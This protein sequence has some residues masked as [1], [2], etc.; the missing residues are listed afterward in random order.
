MANNVEMMHKALRNELESYIRAQYLEKNELLLNV[1]GDRLDDENLLYR[2][3]YIE[4]TPAYETVENGIKKVDLPEW[5]KH[6]FLSLSQA[7]LGV[8]PSPYKHQLDALKKAYDGHDLFISTGTG[9]GKT[10]CFIWPLLAKLCCEAKMQPESWEKRGIRTIIMYPM[11]ALV[12]DQIS[13]LRRLIGDSDDKFLS[14]FKDTTTENT[15]RPQFGMYTGRTPYPGPKIRNPEDLKLAESL[16]HLLTDEGDKEYYKQLL[17]DGKIPAKKDLND[18]IE[19]LKHH[20]HYTDIDDAEL[21]TRFEMQKTC[22]DIL[23]TNYSM[24]ELMLIR[25]RE[26]DI[27]SNT[28]EWLSSNSQNKILFIIDEAHMYRGSAGGEVALLIRRLFHRLGISRERV[29]FIL[30]TASMPHEK[31]EDI[32][33]VHRFAMDLTATNKDSFCYISGNTQYLPQQGLLPIASKKF[34]DYKRF[35][36]SEKLLGL[37]EFWGDINP[38]CRNIQSQEEFSNWLYQNVTAYK[39]F[40]QLMNLCRG[41]ACSVDDIG[42]EIFSELEPEERREAVFALLT[43]ASDAKDV[44]GNLLFPI[45]AH[46]LFRGLQGIFACTNPAC[47]HGQSFGGIKLGGLY[48]SLNH[49]S[50]SCGGQIYELINDRRCGAVFI[51]GYISQK[52]NKKRTFLWRWPGAITEKMYELHLFVPEE[53]K[54]Y[55]MAKKHKM[56]PCYLDSQGGYL[57]FDD[58]LA[59]KPGILKLYYSEDYPI[60][61]RPDIQSFSTCPHCGHP[62][63]RTQLTTFRV[64]G[65]QPFY[66]L[67]KAQFNTQPSIKSKENNIK[68][69]NAGRKVLLFSDSRQRAAKLARDM[70]QA[71]DDLAV[72]QLFVKAANDAASREEEIT[73]DELYGYFV[74]EA[75]NDNVSLFHGDSRNTFVKNCVE[76]RKRMEFSKRRGVTFEPDLKF[77][78]NSPQMMKKQLIHL[79]CGGFNTLYDTALA[80]VEPKQ[81]YFEDAIFELEE[82]GISIDEQEFLAVFNAW[83]LDILNKN[84]ALGQTISDVE[85]LEILPY[86]IKLGLTQ[87]WKFSNN[88][89]KIMGW[90][91]NGKEANAWKS[92]L[93]TFLDENS[94]TQKKYL[95]MSRIVIKCDFKHRWFRCRDCSELSPFILHDAC[96]FCG[97]K[98]IEPMKD[99]DL[100]AMDF[101]RKPVLDSLNS[102]NMIHVIDTEEHTAQLSHNDQ[103][104]SLWAKT[105]QYEMRFQDLLK[106]EETPV[107]VLSSTTTMEVG[108]DIGSLVAVGLRNM[109]PMREN[110]Q[111]RAGRA[112][113]RG[114]ELSTIVT[115]CEDGPNDTLYFENPEPMFCGEPRKP[116]IDIKSEKLLFRH[117]NLIAIQQ[118][119]ID[120]DSSVD[121]ITAIGF[122]ECESE[123]FAFLKTFSLKDEDVLIPVK[124]KE[125]IVSVKNELQG[126]IK[127]LNNKIKLHP[128]IYEKNNYR[129]AKSLLDALYEESVI[130]TY[131][132]PRNVVSTYISGNNALDY[133]IDRGL[134]IAISEYAPGRSIVVDKSTYQVGGLYYYGSERTKGELAKPARAFI[135]DPNY[136]KELYS[137][138]HCGWFGFKDDLVND[139][140]PFCQSK[141]VFRDDSPMIRPWGFA[142]VN[143]QSTPQSQIDEKF[144]YS[145]APLYSTLPEKDNMV[146][147]NGFSHVQMAKRDDQRIIMVNSG[148]T[149]NGFWLCKD[150]GA[151]V[152]ANVNDDPQKNPITIKRPYRSDCLRKDCKHDDRIRVKLGYD[153]ITDMLVLDIELDKT[154]INT[155]MEQNKNPWLYRAG[156][157]IA[158]ALRL[159]A[160]ELMDLEFT[161]I[162]TGFRLRNYPDSPYAHVDV[163]LY[164]SLSSGAGYSSGLASEIND[165]LLQTEELLEKCILDKEFSSCLRHYRNSMYHSQ[166]DEN[167]AL[168]LMRWAKSGTMPKPYPL[169]KQQD[170]LN[171]FTSILGYDGVIIGSTSDAIFVKNARKIASICIYPAMWAAPFSDKD[172][173]ISDFEVKYAKPI[174]VEKILEGLK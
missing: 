31:E 143:G 40:T 145:E 75:V 95:E 77:G 69:P 106:K 128:A 171:P 124:S 64:K 76:T 20:Q 90:E 55:S 116:W 108:I 138:R 103:R 79:F 122:S 42:K 115:F 73:L 163:F 94:E 22:P 63:N 32:I 45:K 120:K 109:P 80:W 78:S 133:Q 67:I 98:E 166:I 91:K 150:C 30:T 154:R 168:D 85:R 104:D 174:G 41:N 25:P 114:A 34:L 83:V 92:A 28:I 113:R 112:G 121:D 58:S 52:H 50:C 170:M 126:S 49:N 9:S 19:R 70:S 137:C 165:L 29:H 43:I 144:S 72:M 155:E 33:A 173:C 131:S 151:A 5:L 130:P 39:P 81:R 134:D 87:D 111:Q 172:I 160:C 148:P 142:P 56:K 23:I 159:K 127:K 27:W 162:N 37:I 167:A 7:G 153:F 60:K 136:A 17:H 36:E 123:F 125:F 10:E 86:F 44:H 6:F 135:E 164:D 11:N 48:T 129:K 107:D 100:D 3:P 118:F 51:K 26:N 149:N 88:I 62:L 8:Y 13:R 46:M 119:L 82:A 99:K 66:N 4:T 105:E 141:D 132:F 24:L 68:Y 110:Y 14:I 12:A 158:E 16:S 102:N 38:E 156:R 96:P 15:R 21:I 54:D 61:G 140:C 18:Y 35:E 59:G 101:W 84:G 74:M 139:Q 53:G 89:Y 65:N 161:E 97:S 147:I 146:E 157:T 169:N 93:N 2:V 1:L 71:S 47:P 57:N 117:V 152:P